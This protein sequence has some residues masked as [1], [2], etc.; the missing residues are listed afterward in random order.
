M[1]S[2]YDVTNNMEYGFINRTILDGNIMNIFLIITEENYG[3]IDDDYY[4]CHGY[5]IIR[6]T[7]PYDLQSDLNI[8]CKVIYSVEILC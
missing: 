1:N 5:Y 2:L 7:Y 4:A 3:D 8:D 6:F